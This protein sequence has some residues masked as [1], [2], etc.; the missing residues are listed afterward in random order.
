[1]KT[2]WLGNRT[3]IFIN[4]NEKSKQPRQSHSTHTYYLSDILNSTGYSQ[5]TLEWR[6]KTEHFPVKLQAGAAS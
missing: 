1:M 5:S 2:S 3:T 6:G 4:E